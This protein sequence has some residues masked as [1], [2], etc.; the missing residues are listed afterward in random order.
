MTSNFFFKFNMAKKKLS[1]Y[2]LSNLE[3]FDLLFSIVTLGDL[4]K[5]RQLMG[6]LIK[7]VFGRVFLFSYGE[8]C[9]AQFARHRWDPA[10]KSLI[11]FLEGFPPQNL[12][13]VHTKGNSWIA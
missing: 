11:H 10:Y 9:P 13:N 2:Y 1:D 6:E 8:I 7:E 3:R 12:R 5:F 4:H